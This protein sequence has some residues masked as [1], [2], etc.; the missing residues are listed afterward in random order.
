VLVRWLDDE[1]KF[2]ERCWDPVVQLKVDGQSVV[3]AVQVL[4]QC[5]RLIIRAERSGLRPR[6]GRSRDFR[7]L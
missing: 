4:D 2:G 6:I 1:G 5:M 7:R 3:T